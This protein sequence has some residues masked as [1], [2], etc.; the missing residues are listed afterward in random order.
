MRRGPLLAALTGI[1]C[2]YAL[3]AL[4]K[5]FAPGGDGR[6]AWPLNVAHRGASAR[7]PENT[8]AAFRAAVEAG[9]G[10]LEMDAHLTRDGHPVVLHDPT[11]DRTT[12][13]SGV[14]AGMT[15][16]EV[17]RL[18]AGGSGRRDERVPTLTEV[19]TAFPGVPLNIDVKDSVPGAEKAVLDALRAAGTERRALVASFQHRVLRRIRRAAGG[20]YDTGASRPEIGVFWA[21]SRLRLEALISPA[22]TALQVP[23]KYR[24]LRVVTPRFVRAAHSRGVRVDVWTINEPGEMRELLDMG[25][26]SVMTDRPEVLAEVLEGR[27]AGRR[28][29]F[30]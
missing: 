17:R 23:T 22:Y 18:D 26:D 12:G 7:F 10:G 27:K 19:L 25:V 15:L 20:E 24:G 4:R 14:V 11:V 16:A 2:L 3:A 13:G 1:S 9:A 21:L 6:R 8:L 28:R 5:R 29:A 30:P